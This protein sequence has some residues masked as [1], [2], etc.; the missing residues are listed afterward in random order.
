MQSKITLSLINSIIDAYRK[1]EGPA[2]I[3]MTS[4]CR[5]AIRSEIPDEHWISVPGESDSFYG[6]PVIIDDSL[7]EY[8]KLSPLQ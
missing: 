3:R 8:W 7:T 4:Y 6:I 5:T 2:Y 1:Q